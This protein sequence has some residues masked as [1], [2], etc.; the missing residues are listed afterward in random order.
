MEVRPLSTRSDATWLRR[1]VGREL[2]T[3]RENSVGP[4]GKAIT[5]TE[6]ATELACAQSKITS[7]EQGKFRLN[8]RDVRDLAILYAAPVSARDRLIQWAK[9]STEPL[10]WSP[11]VE[12][13]EDWFADLVGGE[14][15]AEREVTYEQMFIPGIVQTRAY[16]E[17]VTAISAEAWTNG[18]RDLIVSLRMERQEQLHGDDAL[19]LEA[20]LEETALRRP[21]GGPSVM[22]EQLKE[23][24][25]L[26]QLENISVRVLPTS[27]GYHKAVEGRFDFL[28]FEQFP[29]AVYLQHNHTA[30]AHYGDDL[31]LVEGYKLIVDELRQVALSETETA[32]FVRSII[33]ELYSTEEQ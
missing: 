33:S 10:W 21:I 13:V 23:L 22:R 26:S 5:A 7:I 8:W 31:G 16:A 17:E 6:A 12:V 18:Q 25:R 4:N 20:F 30:G 27:I 9:R 3:L 11:Y 1:R 14:G 24:I 2:R 29:S 28:S 19:R 32:K 15:E